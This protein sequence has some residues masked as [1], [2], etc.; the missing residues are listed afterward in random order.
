MIVATSA[1]DS[2]QQDRQLI[3]LYHRAATECSRSGLVL[4]VHLRLRTRAR[5][6]RHL[7]PRWRMTCQRNFVW[8]PVGWRG[9]GNGGWALRSP[10]GA[11]PLPGSQSEPRAW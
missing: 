1:V 3:Q 10:R 5:A 2:R 11:P 6:G 9:L 8:S 4:L 7:A